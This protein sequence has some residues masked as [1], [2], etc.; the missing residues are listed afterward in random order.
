[1]NILYFNLYILYLGLIGMCF[2]KV[3]RTR[4]HILLVQPYLTNYRIPVFR[5]LAEKYDIQLLASRSQDYGENF[6][7]AGLKCSMVSETRFFNRLYWQPG[8]LSNILVHKPD[9]LFVAANPRYIST[10]LALV[11]SKILGIKVFLHGQG[12]FKKNKITFF[13]RLIYLF[14]Y[15]F[16]DRYVAYTELSKESLRG[17]HIY[18]KVEVADNSISNAYPVGVKNGDEVGIL[19]VGRIRSGCFL[20]MLIEACININKRLG[21]KENKIILNVVGGGPELEVLVDTYSRY[22]YIKFWGEIYDDSKISEIS[23][24]C[25]VGCYPGDA[26]L[27]VLHLMSLSLPVIIHSDMSRHMGPEPSYVVDGI[28]GVCFKRGDLASLEDSIL[29]I[30]GDK[31]LLGTMQRNAFLRYGEL[32]NPPLHTRFAAIIDSVF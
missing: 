5:N 13:S 22:E 6:D 7:H 10:M 3:L 30:R 25:F 26:G 15:Y 21:G 8:L 4:K 28:N 29:N 2:K 31:A 19:F 18:S 27:S 17:L 9:A 1:M 24:S 32:V 20:S 16:S 11:L 12:L 23:K 14:Y